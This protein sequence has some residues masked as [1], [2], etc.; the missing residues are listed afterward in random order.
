MREETFA[1]AYPLAR[2][3]AEVRSAVA[4]AMASVLSADRDDLE[5]EAVAACWR[6]LPNYDPTRASLTT[7]IE[8]VVATRIASVVRASRRRRVLRPLDLA[9]DRC[10]NPGFS[11]HEL[12][13]DVE[14]LLGVCSDGERRLA[15]VLME[16]SPSQASRMLGV[17]RSTVYE[18]I[19]LL[20][21]RFST[22]GLGPEHRER[23]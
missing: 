21:A 16:N 12:R 15:L 2:R 7:Y 9:L 23:R 18:R 6:T 19:K 22:A 10:A 17:A 13:I 3:A 1:K 14:R 20:R 4:V 8:C 5:Q 11:R